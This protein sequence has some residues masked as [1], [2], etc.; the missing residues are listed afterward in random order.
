MV[1]V[2]FEALRYLQKPRTSFKDPVK[3]FA[4]TNLRTVWETTIVVRHV[5]SSAPDLGSR[6]HAGARSAEIRV[7]RQHERLDLLCFSLT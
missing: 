7:P 4:T 1:E 3:S 6:R 2:G 5:S